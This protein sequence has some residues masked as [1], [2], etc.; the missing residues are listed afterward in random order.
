MKL[1]AILVVVFSV[2]VARADDGSGSAAPAAA[3]VP[4]SDARKACTA[5]MNADPSFAKAIVEVADKQAADKRLEDTEKEHLDAAQ[6]IAKDEKHVILAYAAMWLVAA[7][8]V[9]FLWLR[10][11]KLVKEI[12]LL[13]R[14]LEKEAA[15]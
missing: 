14:D 3:P 11:Q 13:K 4:V 15:T 12:A 10:Q 5:A 9:L 7:G 1:L 2:G 6:H 8:F